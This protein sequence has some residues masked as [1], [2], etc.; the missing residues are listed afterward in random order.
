MTGHRAW[1]VDDELLARYVDG[2]ADAAGGSSVEH[3]VLRCADCR[4]RVNVL[5]VAR[6]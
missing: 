2:S 3:H 6:P 1:H 5:A 4:A